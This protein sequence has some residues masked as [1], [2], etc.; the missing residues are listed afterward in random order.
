MGPLKTHYSEEFGQFICRKKRVLG[1]NNLAENFRAAYLTTDSRQQGFCLLIEIFSPIPI[2]WLR[3]KG[4]LMEE[5]TANNPPIIA[6]GSRTH[7]RTDGPMVTPT[8]RPI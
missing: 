1:S 8:P 6:S 3:N 2:L 5:T 4:A 7:S